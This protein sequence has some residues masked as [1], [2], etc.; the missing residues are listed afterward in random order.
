MLLLAS[1]LA[2]Q[3][4]LTKIVHDVVYSRALIAK[5]DDAEEG[6][7]FYFPCG[8]HTL[9]GHLYEGDRT[10]A[11]VVLVPG[12]R[13]RAQ[14]Y[15]PQIR[16]LN[17]QGFPVFALDC[18][19]QGRSGGESSAGLPQEWIDLEAALDFLGENGR[20]GREKLLLF[21]HSAGG[22]AVCCAAKE[23][24]DVAGVVSVSGVNSAM[25]ALVGVSS[26]KVGSLARLNY[27]FLYLCEAMLFGT[28]RVDASA[29]ERLQES[30]VPALIVHGSGDELVAPDRAG[31]L[32]HVRGEGPIRTLVWDVPGQNGHTSLLYEEG[33]ANRALM[34]EIC[35]FYESCLQ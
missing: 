14:T 33:G 30:G 24:A 25:E 22:Y 7:L 32:S 20:F 1:L 28:E 31:I 6:E 18:S 13:S 26:E 34:D 21:G 5:A 3:F 19:G 29:A 9:C 10:D 8:R 23:C 11:L 15:L 4:V 35:R 17:Q 12:L 27:P 2:F 16:V